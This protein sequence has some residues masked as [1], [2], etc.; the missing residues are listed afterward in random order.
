MGSL[1]DLKVS[2]AD[3][4]KALFMALPAV[5]TII[6]AIWYFSAWSE[7]VDLRLDDIDKDLRSIHQHYE[8]EK[9][10]PAPRLDRFQLA[11]PEGKQWL[12]NGRRILTP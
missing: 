6:S 9:L 5:L 7:R 8:L 10:P 3:L 2:A 4:I 1:S 11:D 12:P